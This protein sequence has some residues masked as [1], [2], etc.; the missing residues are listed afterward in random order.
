[1]LSGVLSWV[2]RAEMEMAFVKRWSFSISLTPASDE[3][4]SLLDSSE[5][6]LLEAESERESVSESESESEDA[7]P[8]FINRP[9]C[10]ALIFLWLCASA[11]S[12]VSP[13]CWLK[14]LRRLTKST[15]VLSEVIDIANE[16]SVVDAC[17]ISGMMTERSLGC[18][19]DAMDFRMAIIFM[20]LCAYSERLAYI[21]QGNASSSRELCR[22]R[23]F[24]SFSCCSMILKRLIASV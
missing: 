12:D 18:F 6:E 13:W 8:A 4:L 17:W 5:S 11:S 2:C 10:L 3:V 1:M 14:T 24:V 7:S 20:I 15:N 21:R 16:D 9:C 19:L 23:C 22:K